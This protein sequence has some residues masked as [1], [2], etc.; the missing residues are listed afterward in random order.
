L[1]AFD[2]EQVL[3]SLAIKYLAGDPANALAYQ[4][5]NAGE[6]NTAHALALFD[7]VAYG[8]QRSGLMI[9]LARA[10]QEADSRTKP[11][12]STSFPGPRDPRPDSLAQRAK[13]DIDPGG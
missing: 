4:A 6:L 13:P 11:P 2:S 7:T 12:K 10:L 5:L 1:T 3:P 9:R 8:P